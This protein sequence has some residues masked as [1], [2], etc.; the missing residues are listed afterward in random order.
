MQGKK[1]GGRKKGAKNKRT[2]AKEAELQKYRRAGMTP[3]QVMQSAIGVFLRR[4]TLD[5]RGRKLPEGEVDLNLLERACTIAKDAAPYLHPRLNAIQ[6]TGKD[7]EPI[8][9]TFGNLDSA[10]L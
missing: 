3:L 4:A 2:L 8:R 10:A 9:V 7:G 5:K 1:T 6:H